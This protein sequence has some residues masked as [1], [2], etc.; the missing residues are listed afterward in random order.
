MTMEADLVA[1]LRPLCARV[2]PDMAPSGSAPPWVTFQHIGGTPL[3]HVDGTA[4]GLRHTMLQVNVWDTTRAAALAL[5][6]QVED[7]ICLHAGWQA[8]ASTE[9][10]GE[11]EPDMALYGC[12]QDFDIWAGRT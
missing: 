2:H 11:I 5:A 6:R 3:R 9:P 10:V 8:E 1:L 7:A 4:S 12:R